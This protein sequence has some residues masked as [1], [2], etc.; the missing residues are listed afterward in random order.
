LIFISTPPFGVFIYIKVDLTK[1][2]RQTPAYERI[3][4]PIVS[5]VN[6]RVLKCFERVP[7]IKNAGLDKNERYYHR[8]DEQLRQFAGWRPDFERA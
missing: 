4:S 7:R 8:T 5:T 1:Y 6:R 3:I 2:P